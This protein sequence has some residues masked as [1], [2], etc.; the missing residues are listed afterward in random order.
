MKDGLYL[1]KQK[2]KTITKTTSANN[3]L[4]VPAIMAVK[5]VLDSDVPTEIHSKITKIRKT[6][7]YIVEFVT[8]GYSLVSTCKLIKSV[9]CCI[10]PIVRLIATFVLPAVLVAVKV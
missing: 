3:V 5:L 9:G 8:V 1:I 4:H 6:R 7:I 10:I 2:T